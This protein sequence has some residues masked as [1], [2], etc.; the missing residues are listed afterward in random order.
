M[1]YSRLLLLI[2]V[3]TGQAVTQ[4]TA[5]ATI[6]ED[7]MKLMLGDKVLL[8]HETDGFM[9]LR[10]IKY[11]PNNDYFVVIGCGYE[12]NDNVGFLFKSD[13]SDKI[14]ITERWDFIL[15]DKVEWSADGTKLFYYRINST[16]AEPPENSPP[17]GWV[18]VDLMTGRKTPAV[19]FSGS[20]YAS[21]VKRPEGTVMLS[22][23]LINRNSGKGLDIVDRSPKDGANIQQWVYADQPNQNWEI[24]DVGNNEVAIISAFS[25]R[26]LDIQGEIGSNGSKVH[27]TEW[28]GSKTQ[29]WRLEKV[30]NSWHRVVNVGS[31]KCLDVSNY[32]KENGAII[33]QWECHG[34]SNQQWQV[35]R[36]K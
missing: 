31:N 18:E 9:S 29:R 6:S 26:V 4:Q 2:F 17:E 14:K 15:Q 7:R 8:H 12:C 19:N 36:Q 30:G 11:S 28:S 35:G 25:G 24:V 20:Y 33:W 1:F 16:G 22:G 5:L 27:Q 34:R 32:S 21:I 13:G 23:P 10:L 3:L